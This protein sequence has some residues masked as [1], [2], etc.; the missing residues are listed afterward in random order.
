M[1]AWE[2]FILAQQK[3]IGEAAV[4][5]WLRPLKVVH[6]DACNLYLEAKTPF[7]AMWFEEHIRHKVK[8][9][10]FNN[11][12]H[13]IKVHL[14]VQEETKSG[15]KKKK[16]S[17]PPAFTLTFDPIDPSCTFE[18]FVFGEQSVAF[19][20]ISELA[21]YASAEKRWQDPTLKLGTFNPIYLYGQPGTGKTHLLMALA[22]SL[23]KRGTKVLFVHTEKFTQHVVDAI[24][25]ASMQEFRKAYRHVDCLIIDDIHLLSR[26][27]A[28][29]EEL[30]HTFNTLHTAGK[31]I[32]LGSNTP[33][34]LLTEIE[35]RL[36][37][38]FEWG[39]ILQLERLSLKELKHVLKYRCDSLKL[40][41]KEEVM[42]FL[43]E[44]FGTTSP[45]SLHR[46]FEALVLRIKSERG[47]NKEKVQELLSDLLK[48]EVEMAL[49]P[50]KIIKLVSDHFGIRTDDILGRSQAQ[51]CAM[52]R[53]IA[54]Y[55]VR[56]E[57]NVPF[58][59]IGTIF[60][61][62]HS[63]VM[64]SVKQIQKKM[65]SQDKELS[66]SISVLLRSLKPV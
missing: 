13:H 53:Q 55:L 41:L 25:S 65:D 52:P 11:N 37:S 35:P 26:R 4:N 12:H 46:A 3:E 33:P 38:R 62:D 32:I 57:L 1:E 31:Q 7:Q 19:Q 66:S 61:R 48:E 63:T 42:D 2:K 60:S 17:P 23:Q 59:K 39:L 64:T 43:I 14:T 30:F 24:R 29:Q 58:I 8:E 18:N 5:E 20:L 36:I 27:A 15:F 47:V 45:R 22:Q 56:T 10:L 34:H 16:T 9:R 49:S 28:T 50:E 40:S 6:F 44:S 51:D 54:M 21:G